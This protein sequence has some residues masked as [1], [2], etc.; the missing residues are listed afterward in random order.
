MDHLPPFLKK[1]EQFKAKGVDV[2]VVLAA[3]DE[4]VMSGWARFE[5]LE[6][7]VLDDYF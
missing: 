7:K 1:Y 3:N 6:N 4:Y 2:I 5:G